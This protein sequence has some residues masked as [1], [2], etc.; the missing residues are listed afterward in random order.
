MDL[1]SSVL[2]FTDA[3]EYFEYAECI[4]KFG[5]WAGTAEH[6]VHT[7]DFKAINDATLNLFFRYNLNSNEEPTSSNTRLESIRG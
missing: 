7:I 1:D 3:A 5:H 4:E 6:V 2:N